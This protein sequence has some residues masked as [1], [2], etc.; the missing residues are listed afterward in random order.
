[1]CQP[2]PVNRIWPQRNRVGHLAHVV[3]AANHDRGSIRVAEAPRLQCEVHQSHVAVQLAPHLAPRRTSG[4]PRFGTS[5]RTCTCNDK[6][7]P[8]PAAKT[9]LHL[10]HSNAV[11]ST[12]RGF[13]PDPLA[14]SG[15]VDGYEARNVRVLVATARPI[16]RSA[17]KPHQPTVLADVARYPEALRVPAV[18]ARVSDHCEAVHV[19]VVDRDTALVRQIGHGFLLKGRHRFAEND[20]P[21]SFPKM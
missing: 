1:M 11:A 6:A 19:I 7:S 12:K 2:E 14:R 17:Q 3:V 5:R 8:S 21:L 13:G 10:Q 9:H 20:R 16:V 15:V 4:M 18:V